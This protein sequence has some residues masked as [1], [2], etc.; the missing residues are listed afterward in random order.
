LSWFEQKAVS[1]LLS[2]LYLGVKG[3]YLAPRLPAWVN[4]DILKV[5]KERYEI[6][7]VSTPEKD[8]KGLLKG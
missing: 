7:L 6:R 4:E 8:F 3:V 2:L 1:I 5:L